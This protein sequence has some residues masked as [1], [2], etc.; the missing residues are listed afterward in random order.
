MANLLDTDLP[1]IEID[2]ITKEFKATDYFEDYLYKIVSSLGGEG[3]SAVGD[4]LNGSSDAD[5]VIY[6]F[7]LVKSLIKRVDELSNAVESID[8]LKANVKQ[9]ETETM[10]F[11]GKIKSL[12]Y[13]AFD[14]EWV[15]ARSNAVITLP[16]DPLVN[17]QVIVSNGDGTL[18][19]V[20]GNG[21][22]IKYTTTDSSIN[23]RRKGTSLHFQLFEDESTKYW[24]IR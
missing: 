15:E 10:G 3:A 2:P 19:K 5:K 1:I 8:M 16:A 22:N 7:S 6:Y 20:R 17:H 4:I 13:T 18:I 24:R 11:I 23:I 9:I 21:N 14:K 12:S